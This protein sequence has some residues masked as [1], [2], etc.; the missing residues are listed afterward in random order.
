MAAG[1]VLEAPL[2]R[3]AEADEVSIRSKHG[4]FL[5]SERLNEALLA[6]QTYTGEDRKLVTAWLGIRNS[7][8][9]PDQ[10]SPT[11]DQVEGMLRGGDGIHSA[12]PCMI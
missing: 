5:S 7:G 1:V 2:R 8:A 6:E 9:H 11:L 12:T 3:L 10:V 4:K